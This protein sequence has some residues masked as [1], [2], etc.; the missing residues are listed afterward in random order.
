MLQGAATREVKESNLH[1]PAGF[2][3]PDGDIPPTWSGHQ[4]KVYLDSEAAIDG[5]INCVRMNPE[6]EGKPKQA[7]PFVTP[8]TSLPKSSQTTYH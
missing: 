8:F 5:A 6:K 7:W 4:W 3:K 1:A 2:K